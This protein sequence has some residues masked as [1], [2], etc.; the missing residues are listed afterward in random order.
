MEYAWG[1][2]RESHKDKLKAVQSLRLRRVLGAFNRGIHLATGN[3]N[4]AFY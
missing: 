4:Q 1:G 3:E 2:T